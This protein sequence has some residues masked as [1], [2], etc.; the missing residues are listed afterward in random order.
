MI[1]F[2]FLFWEEERGAEALRAIR[3]AVAGR[4]RA[5]ATSSSAALNAPPA[6][7][8]PAEHRFK[9]G[10]ALMIAGFG[11][12]D[13]HAEAVDRLRAALPPLFDAVTPMP[14]TALQQ[15]FDQANCWG[16]YY[17]EKSTRLRRADRRGDRRDGR[18]PAA[19]TLAD[20]RHARLLPG[21]GLLRGRPGRDGVRGHARPAV[22]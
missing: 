15:M 9:A 18:A 19:A 4:C 11:D 17:Y 16:Q 14:Y 20:E 8:V 7:F 13:E 22:G 6:P 10:F 21:R 12:P 5:R 2:A 3:E 1:Q